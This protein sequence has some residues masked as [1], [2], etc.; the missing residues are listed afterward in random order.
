MSYKAVRYLFEVYHW[1]I[2]HTLV[3]S[4]FSFKMWLLM[5]ILVANLCEFANACKWRSYGKTYFHKREISLATFFNLPWLHEQVRIFHINTIQNR[6]YDDHLLK[7]RNLP[8]TITVF[9]TSWLY[10][11]SNMHF[12]SQWPITSLI[13]VHAW[14]KR[15]QIATLPTL[16]VADRYGSTNLRISGSMLIVIL[17]SGHS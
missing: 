3:K 13:S 14:K 2:P 8:L 7:W 12:L 1:L 11:G 15:P 5:R 17:Q 4:T 9:S 16:Q 6:V 10:C